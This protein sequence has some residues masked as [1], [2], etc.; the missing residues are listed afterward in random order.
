MK[1]IPTLFERT[2]EDGHVVHTTH[3]VTPG[4]EWVLRG[5]G[6]ATIKWDGACCALIDGQLYKRYDAKNGKQPPAGAIPCCDPDPV[7]GHWPHWLKCDPNNPADRWFLSAHATDTN[8]GTYE[9]IGPHF[10]NN[11]Y[12][13]KEDWLVPHGKHV[14]EVDDR[15]F[16]GIRKFLEEYEIEG[17]VFWKD[18]EPQC[19]IKRRDFGLPWPVA[20]N[21]VPQEQMKGENAP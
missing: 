20:T 3:C 1:K 13:L 2:F 9:A 15:S 18:G 7:T 16:D 11:P 4:M 6:I 12:S 8:D 5:E 14:V 19:K 17:L 10:N 21:I